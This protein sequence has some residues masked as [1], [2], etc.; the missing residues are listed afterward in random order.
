ME[1]FYESGTQDAE[2]KKSLAHAK[3]ACIVNKVNSVT[4]IN[5]ISLLIINREI[6]LIVKK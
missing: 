2:V 6:I 1:D 3:M 4:F 5:I